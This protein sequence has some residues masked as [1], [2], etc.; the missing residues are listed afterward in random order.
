M[1]RRRLRALIVTVIIAA[2][3]SFLL[4]LKST[5]TVNLRRVTFTPEQSINLNAVLNRN[6]SVV[7][8]ES[9]SDIAD[10][11]AG[12]SFHAMKASISSRDF[13]FSE[14]AKSRAAVAAISHDGST[15]A[16]S[17]SEDLI[18]ENS[19][20]NFEIYSAS[21]SGLKQLTHTSTKNEQQDRLVA[22]NFQPSISG[23]GKMIAFSATVPGKVDTRNIYTLD[24][25]TGQLEQV[26]D[27]P[28]NTRSLS[29][30]TNVDGSLIYFIKESDR[31]RDLM[32]FERSSGQELLLE[33]NVPALMLTDGP[34]LSDD[35]MR[36]VYSK[37]TEP[38]QTQVYLYDRG[39]GMSRQLTHLP[40]RVTDVKLQPA[41]SGDGLRVTFATR[42]RVVNTS[43]GSVELYLIDLPTSEIQQ[44]TD[45][46]AGTTAEILS[47]L[48]AD[49]SLVAFNF[50]RVISAPVSQSEFANNCEIYLAEISARPAF[51]VA[52]VQ[53]AAAKGN[54]R[55]ENILAR[56]T[57]A[58]VKGQHLSFLQKQIDFNATHPPTS[59]LGTSV[60][61]NG[62]L[63][64]LLYISPEEVV[65]VVPEETVTGDAEI[66]VTNGDGFE[67]KAN[68][69]ISDVAPGIFTLSGDGKGVAV[70]MNADT[71]VPEPFDPSSSQ[72][73]ITVFGTG[74]VRA[75]EIKVDLGGFP[76][77]VESVRHSNVPGIDELRLQVP[78]QLRGA[79]AV[80]FLVVA[81]GSESNSV[82]IAFSGSARRDL[83][84]NEFLAD[85]PEG[86]IGDANH[87]GLRDSSDDEFVEII[88]TTAR[89]LDLTGFQL[90]T[91][92][93]TGA[94]DVLRH[95]FAKG[96]ILSAG[97]AIV[98]FGGG[99]VN[100]SDPLFG[101]AQ[102]VAAS[103]R[104]LS[105]TNSGGVITLR[106][107]AG[108][109]ANSVT[110]GNALNLPADQN[111]SVTR[112]P[113][114]D[115]PF[116][117][118]TVAN[119]NDQSR[120]SPGTRIDR[121]EFLPSPAIERIT[122]NPLNVQLEQGDSLQFTAVALDSGST[123]L[124]GVIFVWQSNKKD[125]LTIDSTGLARAISSGEVEVFATARGVDSL[126]AKVM[127]ISPTPTPTPTPSPSPSIS[128]TPTPTP[129][130]TPTPTST[131]TPKPTPTATPTPG[132]SP[133]P[134]ATPISSPSP[135][136]Q[137][138]SL[139]VISE[140]RTRGP[141]GA[142]DEFVEIYNKGD[143]ATDIGGWKIRGSSSAGTITTRM[144]ITIGTVLPPRSHFL[145]T[146]SS[147][148]SGSIIADQSYS[149]G[150]ANDGGIAVTRGDDVPVDQVGLS[151]GS[152]FREGMHLAPLIADSNQSY[153]RKPD[154]LRGN[155]LDT[156]D[157]FSNFQILTPSDPQ[158]MR[159]GEP[160]PS[161]SPTPTQTPTP[162]PTPGP[163]PSPSVN[164]TPT[165]T[166]GPTPSPSVSPTP[167]P[168]PS[169]T[170]L[171]VISQIF[172]GGG[173]SGA[174]FRNDFIEIFNR[175]NEGV[176][177][178][179]W[180]LQ[181]ASATNT[182]WS[183]TPLTSVTLAPGHYYL[184]QEASGGTNGIALPAPDVVGSIAMA[185]T[186]GK[187]ALVRSTT[188]I[189]GTCPSASSIVDLVGYGASATCFR[190]SSP[191]A[192]PSNTN[193]VIRANAGCFDTADN[194]NDFVTAPPAPRNL[195]AP[196]N[197]CVSASLHPI[198]ERIGTGWC[199]VIPLY[200]IVTFT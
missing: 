107:P 24:T 97:T 153:E 161:P 185:A 98:V 70:A 114:L 181:Y 154:G 174:P 95:R 139:I 144:T 16:F 188:A 132:P 148:Y 53:N 159:T 27:N 77:M 106:D 145:A 143:V 38:N 138:P 118:H 41:I 180:S 1:L 5:S 150:F 88:N 179:D 122:L 10:L 94:N 152:A 194:R 165:P 164:P 12:L 186:A 103:S 50:P 80:R 192:A 6:S 190:G 112:R 124:A 200:F 58:V 2:A 119:G 87:D 67:S 176:D 61:V 141:N 177:L 51:G 40:A 66:V 35:G 64:K 34:A 84:I 189:S 11:G 120:F 14:F 170:S 91:R 30:K 105:L 146:N 76:A 102:V 155:S 173:N 8:F 83:M 21:P 142:N 100:S 46:P 121:K 92:S 167:M 81:D 79:G 69:K 108:T 71:L 82:T 78:D 72:L 44:L 74:L 198:F 131:P 57:L 126:P 117:L 85:P 116:V 129:I 75:H 111:Q 3:V 55:T 162:T 39:L 149:S 178:T 89:D 175:G 28:N 156:Q 168:S 15:I 22:G 47:S 187:V 32:L 86:D 113:D 166:P 45:A 68:V 56:G 183:V 182:N 137:P 65:F 104:S 62:V 110:Y 31:G 49:G 151:A 101:R 193:A 25:S 33:E 197:L 23:N 29:P 136:P 63:S 42:R 20:R 171:V 99:V 163:T 184:I 36:L 4:P 93:L 134:T 191:A 18:N 199:G 127:I 7:A 109:A 9:T 26:T 157:N 169:P 17:S 160:V 54:E 59:I 96:T 172:G 48:N 147:G 52:T 90:Q 158:N 43:D 195:L 19:D 60:K 123:E 130:A 115:G 73:C 196:T 140:F 125:V 128:P 133:S 13:S 135:S 37:T